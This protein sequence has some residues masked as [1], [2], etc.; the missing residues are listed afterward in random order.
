VTRNRRELFDDW[1]AFE[2]KLLELTIDVSS[3]NLRTS[4]LLIINEDQT[5]MMH[6]LEDVLPDLLDKVS[7][8]APRRGHGAPR[9]AAYS[10]M[11]R[12]TA[13]VMFLLAN[14]GMKPMELHALVE[15]AR[16]DW[17]P[18]SPIRPSEAPAMLRNKRKLRGQISSLIREGKRLVDGT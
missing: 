12:R 8:M 7:D 9:A 18:V 2:A 14:A 15:H 13:V 16:R 11:R 10:P 6:E 4:L 3:L 1:R 17:L 5:S